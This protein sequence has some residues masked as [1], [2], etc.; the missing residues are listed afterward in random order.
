[1]LLPFFITKIHLFK[2]INSEPPIN[3]VQSDQIFIIKK[4]KKDAF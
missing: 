2:R 1:M 3:F 4:G